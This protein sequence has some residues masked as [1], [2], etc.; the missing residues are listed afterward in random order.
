MSNKPDKLFAIAESQKGYFTTAQAVDCGYPTSN[1]VYHLKAGSWRRVHRGIY[2]LTRFPMTD[3][4]Q[5]VLWSLWSRNRA[6]ISQ[7]VYS[8]QT[9]LSLFELSD[10]MPKRL[11]MTVPPTFRRN[12]P[13]PNAVVLH[14]GILKRGDVE[15]RQ[16]YRV[17]RPLKT[18]SDLLKEA[19]S[20]ED[21]LRQALNEA[22]SRGLITRAQIEKHPQR[23]SLQRLL[24]EGTR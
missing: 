17:T 13:I 1:Q 22:V 16:G 2:R 24:N 6:G 18:L 8:H 4:E 19:V 11:H 14:K 3:D 5:Y 20:S 15:D 7:G 10:I 9:A 12:S 23:T 21:H